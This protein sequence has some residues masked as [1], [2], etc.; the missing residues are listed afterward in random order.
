VEAFI[1]ELG[2]Q[3]MFTRLAVTPAQIAAGSLPTAPPKPG[4]D[5]TCQ[6]DAI[7]PNHLANILRTAIEA[8]IDR[9]AFADV[10]RGERMAR[11]ELVNRLDED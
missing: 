5:Q 4:D 7:A 3:A 2:G 8:R 10:L 9:D 1:E 6:A 11:R